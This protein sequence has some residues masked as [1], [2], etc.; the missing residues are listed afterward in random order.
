MIY[1][2][3]AKHPTERYDVYKRHGEV[4]SSGGDRLDKGIEYHGTAS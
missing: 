1:W 2:Q 3:I 4:F